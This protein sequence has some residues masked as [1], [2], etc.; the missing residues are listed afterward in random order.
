MKSGFTLLEVIISVAVLALVSVF[1][2]QMFVVSDRVNKKAKNIDQANMICMDAI[3]RFKNAAPRAIN[4]HTEVYYDSGWNIADTA[5]AA[6]ILT[7]EI[8]GG[9]DGLHYI[10]TRVAGIDDAEELA[11]INASRYFANAGGGG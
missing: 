1:I 6:F 3:E 11:S 10:D 2:L 5:E 7:V 9:Y 4:G 8:H